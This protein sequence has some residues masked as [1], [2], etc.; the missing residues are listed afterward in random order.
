MP[1]PATQAAKFAFV[2]FS[3]QRD[4]VKD[5]TAGAAWPDIA[6]RINSCE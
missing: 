5:S 6:L 1:T 4:Q 3:L 2:I